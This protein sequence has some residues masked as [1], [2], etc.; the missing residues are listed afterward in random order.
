MPRDRNVIA[1]LVLN[2]NIGGA[3]LSILVDGN[4]GI[5]VFQA[6]LRS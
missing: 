5:H 3:P 1:G 2:D 4:D 6:H